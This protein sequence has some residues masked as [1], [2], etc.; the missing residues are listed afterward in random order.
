MG[1]PVKTQLGD[2]L[3]TFQNGKP[4]TSL[5]FKVFY[6]IFGLA[7]LFNLSWVVLFVIDVYRVTSM[8]SDAPFTMIGVEYYGEMIFRLFVGIVASIAFLAMVII[9][10][11]RIRRFNDNVLAYRR[12]MLHL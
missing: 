8:H 6:F 1:S 11:N 4:R 9:R 5:A 12:A 10:G 7:A 2:K 3:R